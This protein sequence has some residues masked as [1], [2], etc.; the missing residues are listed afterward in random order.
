MILATVLCA[1]IPAQSA[2]HRAS[3]TVTDTNISAPGSLRPAILNAD[4]RPG[5]ADL[6]AVDREV[7]LAPVPMIAPDVVGPG[8][9]DTLRA[10][11]DVSPELCTI[12]V[13]LDF[14]EGTLS[15][16]FVIG[17]R[18]PAVWTVALFMEGQEIPL[19]S[20]ALPVID[21]P[22]S[23]GFSVPGIPPLG[24]IT[25]ATVLTTPSEGTICADEN[26]IDT[27]GELNSP[28]HITSAPVTTATEEQ[29]YIYDVEATDPDAGDVITFSLDL[30]PPGMTIDS[31]SGVIQWTPTDAQLGDN[32]VTVGARDQEGQFDTQGYMISVISPGPVTTIVPDVVGL[33][34]TEAEAAIVAASLLVGAVSTANSDTVPAGSVIG[35]DPAGGS[36]VVESSAVDLVI[37]AGDSGVGQ[38]DRF[39]AS[40]TNTAS[41][42]DPYNDVSLDVTYTRP[43]A[44]TVDFW[45]FY[46]G[47]TA[48][49]IRFMCDQVGTWEYAATFSDGAP[50]INGTFDC[51]SSTIPG[52]LS[53]DETNPM[54]FGFE[55]GAHILIRSF[56]VGDRF[57]AEN[58]DDPADPGDG[59][60]R[61]VFLDW[62]QAQGYNLISVASHYLN[63]E[64]SGRGLGWDTP[65]LWPLD[66]AEYRKMET[67]L[68]ELANRRIMVYPFAGFFGRDSDYPTVEGDQTAYIRYTL[69]RL[70]S[71]WNI[72]L[73]VA[74]PEP[75]LGWM[76]GSDVSRLG[77]EIQSLDVFG[78]PL[79]VHNRTGG[80]PYENSSWTSYGTLQGPKTT[81]LGTLSGG[82]LGSH[83]PSKPLYA[84]ETLWSGNQNHPDYSDDQLRKN[85]YVITMSAAA[86]AFGDMGG[87]NAGDEGNSSSG[88]TGSLD[89]ADRRQW[90]HDI[91]KDVLD[92]FETIPFYKMSP[93]QGLVSNGYCLAETGREYLV[94]LGSPGSVSVAI[95]GGPFS[96]EWINAQNTSDR[97]SGG[98]TSDG[99]GL[100]SPSD[101]D[102][103][104]VHLS[105][106]GAD[107]IHL[108]WTQD[109]STTFTVVWHTWDTAAASDV[110]YRKQGDAVWQ[111]AAGSLRAS[112][113]SGTLHEATLAG[114]LPGTDYE[115][116]VLGDGGVWSDVFTTKT[117]PPAGPADFDF[118][119]VADTGLIGRLDDLATGTEQV[120]DEI[121][122]MNPDLVL[123]GG[124]YAYYSTD[125]RYGTLDTTI[126]AWFNQMEPI[127][128]RSP[129]MPTY[130]NH[131]VL[132]GEGFEEWE[133]RFATPSGSNGQRFYSF[134]VGDVH[135]VSI[136][137]VYNGNPLPE[138]DRN[139]V[140]QDITAAFAAGA[141][142]VVPYFHVAPF[143]DGEN[144]PS[145]LS[146]RAQL[147]PLFEALGVKLVLTAHDQSYERTFPLIGVPDSITLTSS[148]LTCYDGTD[149]VTWVKV[150]PGGK[151]SNRN[152]DFSQWA[153]DPQPFWTAFR[154]NTM[155]TFARV[156]V[157]ASGSLRLEAYGVVGDGTPPVIFDSF[158][159]RLSGGCPASMEFA[160]SFVSVAVE[161][162]GLASAI[163][164]IDTSDDSPASFTLA[165]SVP[166]LSVT[167]TSVTTPA[168]VAFSFD[169]AGLLPGTYRGTVEAT[170]AGFESDVI[171]VELN[172]GGG[173]CT[174]RELVSH[175]GKSLASRGSD[176]GGRRFHLHEPRR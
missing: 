50:G 170:A 56:H 120:R 113:T 63:R 10:N 33:A 101:G 51:V 6:V 38:W 130:G 8:R 77:N 134:D 150:S 127:G 107:Q 147:G 4:G 115:Y 66:A 137:A 2:A 173:V 78:H 26:S 29:L 54:W 96:V 42:A 148:S 55:G 140:E 92:L 52:M 126:D 94:Y 124:D 175:E 99:Q 149:G 102:D 129:M 1:L 76:S 118:I 156:A 35:Q 144:H 139:W 151:L 158:E 100:T 40:A 131:E 159:Y 155:H 164:D 121:A 163:V 105:T 61:A 73:N 116:R 109:P 138:A 45:G 90:R 5:L 141:R 11:A 30:G 133:Q 43:D 64:R 97:R 12:G 132:L 172:V 169:T 117:A 41:Y 125:T 174:S 37:S 95:T 171:L 81:N 104:L 89:L 143:S 15:V 110:E 114:L 59:D 14:N 162:D 49:R 93:C 103:W 86:F 165:E 88:F 44:S 82:L 166:W 157:S 145:N 85:A 71:Y 176:A 58:W 128:A 13:V 69:A 67:I 22:I 19:W 154:D 135:F 142:W 9:A 161:K 152:G 122:A 16:D 18:T 25:F 75:N 168:T 74:G 28:P 39:E 79:S 83:N 70:G 136:L 48:W 23:I 46:D 119:F 98:T 72:L 91:I 80:D 32:L 68:D 57:F 36:V 65:N 31:V 123:L 7:S 3:F 27:G 21:P 60:K 108:S 17:L 160:R 20:I 87:P 111:S 84:Q 47:G 62:F 167:S 153:T 112:G 24:T 106:S 53:V 34:L 146:L